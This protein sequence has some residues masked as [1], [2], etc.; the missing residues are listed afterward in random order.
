MNVNHSDVI[1]QCSSLS[2]LLF[3]NSVREVPNDAIVKY[4]SASACWGTQSDCRCDID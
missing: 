1:Q 2:V 4:K 3:L